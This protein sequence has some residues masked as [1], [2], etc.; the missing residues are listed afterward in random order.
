[1]TK[2]ADPYYHSTAWRKLRRVALER[3][4]GKCVVKG[5]GADA[6]V[7]DHILSRRLGGADTLHNLRCLCRLHDNQ[8]KEQENGGRRSGG[9]PV[10]RACD[11]QGM[12]L[13]PTHPWNR[14]RGV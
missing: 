5:C 7:V 13:D 9:K 2:Q 10:V 6:V 14:G 3:D 1:M 4:G 11:A 8:I 12:P